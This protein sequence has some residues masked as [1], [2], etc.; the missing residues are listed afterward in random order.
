MMLRGLNWTLRG[1]EKAP[2]GCGEKE[3]RC[4]LETRQPEAFLRHQS[5]VSAELCAARSAWID[6]I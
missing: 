5:P 2:L 4:R 3:F 1:H 6:S